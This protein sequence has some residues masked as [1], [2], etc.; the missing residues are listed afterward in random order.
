MGTAWAWQYRHIRLGYALRR[1]FT[2]NLVRIGVN[3]RDFKLIV[4]RINWSYCNPLF[5]AHWQ[6]PV[7]WL[8]IAF[9]SKC[10]WRQF[11]YDPA[12]DQQL[13]STRTGN[14]KSLDMTM[15]VTSQMN[16]YNAQQ[17]VGF[18]KRKFGPQIQYMVKTLQ[19]KV[20][21]VDALH[22]FVNLSKELCATDVILSPWALMRCYLIMSQTKDV[23]QLDKWSNLTLGCEFEALGK[24]KVIDIVFF[25]CIVNGP[26]TSTNVSVF[27]TRH[28]YILPNVVCS[29]SK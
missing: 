10:M 25:Y 8:G 20:M 13:V 18:Y 17:R 22:I 11:N 19:G 15:F 23:Y 9:I 4:G 14:M 1:Y 3:F 16:Y 7:V 26:P 27:C 21:S 29:F 5:C 12:H 6:W 2:T 28:E 24:L